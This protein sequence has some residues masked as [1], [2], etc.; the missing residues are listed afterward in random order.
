MNATP[1][2]GRL[3]DHAVDRRRFL[4]LIATGAAVV[5]IPG[6]LTSCT[7]APAPSSTAN[8]A[9]AG[10][11]IPKYIPVTYIDPDYPSVNGSVPG[12]ES[13]PAELVQSVKTAPGT[14]LTLTA[15]TPL[16]GTIPPTKGNKYYEAVNGLLGS[17]I[18]FQITDGNVY[19]DKL[20]TVLAS[21][22]D[23]PDWVC[24]PTW[25]L[26]P[27]FGSEIVENVFQDLTPFLAGDKVTPYPN[28][29]NISSDAWKFC[30]FNGKLYGLPFPGE[31]ITDAIFYRRDV[32][33]SLGI[34]PDVKNGQDL[35]D[36]AVE[37]TGGNVWG[38]EDLWNTAAIIHAAPPKWKLDGDKLVHRV[39]SDEYRA[40]L[41]WNA[42]L[43]KSGAV[44]PDAVADQNGEAKSRFQSG[45]SLIANDGV[46]GWHEALRDNLAANP[47]YWQQP[48]DP[49]AADGGTPV[50]WKG[51]PANI[52]S[53]L[54][55]TDDEAKITELLA[56]ANVLAAPYGTTEY[57]TINN[58]VEGVHYTRGDD[59]LPVPTELAATELQPTYIFL[60]DPPI[61]ETHV[62]YPGYVKAA[63]EWK[64]NAAQY[65]TDPLFYAQQIVEPQQYASIGQPFV[66]LEKDIS[67]GRKSMDDLDAAIET[68][69]SSGGEELRAFYQDILDSQS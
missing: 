68:W 62:Q 23:V 2:F 66:D 54:K 29:A 56:L 65:A 19:G 8:A 22:K 39:E 21:A 28:L 53:F 55:K 49:F 35:I 38:A 60:V 58:G 36:L 40:A 4:G 1:T 37:L 69:R 27:R 32:L 30:V 47:S 42:A 20:A 9:A 6:L 52:F 48:F 11:V 16:W 3:G 46:G 13:I 45:K 31:V 43:F 63:S 51:N 44:H 5:G 14:G 50:L 64:A 34:T 33:E 7:T 24:V 41:E 18:E 17:D 10:D 15:M 12:F 61:S 26:P 59:G 57:D 25:N 67:R